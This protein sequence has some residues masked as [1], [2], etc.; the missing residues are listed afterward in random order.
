M[1]KTV[2]LI[3]VRHGEAAAKWGES[4]DPGL[5]ERGRSQARR[6]ADENHGHTGPLALYTSPLKRAVETMLP[7]QDIRDTQS[8]VVPELAEIP[9][10]HIPMG[11]RQAWLKD[12]KQAKWQTQP[13]N[14]QM[15]RQGIINFMLN[16]PD[17]SLMT[18]HFAVINVAVGYALGLEDIFSFQPANCSATIFELA[19]GK[20]QL[21]EKGT[22]AQSMINL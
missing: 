16:C 6:A 20:L 1:G 13:Q 2:R 22:E 7:F 4:K 3:L 10:Q 5:S 19:D 8:I 18:T 12:L 21:I 17:D 14:L 11:K 9:S 15:W